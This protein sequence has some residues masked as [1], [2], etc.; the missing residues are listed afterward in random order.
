MSGVAAFNET[1]DPSRKATCKALQTLFDHRLGTGTSRLF[2]GSPVWFADD[3][4]LVG[5]SLKKAGVAILFWSG[6]GF[7]EPGL[8]PV[9]KH[10]AAEYIIP[11]HGEIPRDKLERWLTESKTII[12]DYKNIAKRNGVLELLSS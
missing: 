4:P 1:L 12:W 10:K 2:H 8:T 6:Q 9:G 7:H 3:N 5:Y 11:D